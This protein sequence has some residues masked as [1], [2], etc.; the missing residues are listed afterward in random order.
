[1]SEL[2]LMMLLPLRGLNGA[3]RKAEARIE[4]P[5]ESGVKEITFVGLNG[6]PA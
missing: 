6:N 1:M 5:A 4:P 2:E 3:I